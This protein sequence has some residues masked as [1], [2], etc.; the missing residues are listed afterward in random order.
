MPASQLGMSSQCPRSTAPFL[1]GHLTD[2]TNLLTINRW[3]PRCSPGRPARHGPA[4][5]DKWRPETHAA[6]PAYRCYQGPEQAFQA[7]VEP[8]LAE[9][10]ARQSFRRPAPRGMPEVSGSLTPDRREAAVSIDDDRFG[11]TQEPPALREEIPNPETGIGIGAR[12][13]PDTFEPEEDPE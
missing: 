5:A 6:R 7:R 11:D 13:E 4:L 2:T 12:N 3:S 9:V 10:F 1:V 8:D